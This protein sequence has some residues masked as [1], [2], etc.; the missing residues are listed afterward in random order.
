MPDA[1]K[2]GYQPLPITIEGFNDALL[3][4]ACPDDLEPIPVNTLYVGYPMGDCAGVVRSVMALEQMVEEHGPGVHCYHEIVHNGWVRRIFEDM[5]VV[6]VNSP[7]EVPE[8]SP[9]MLSAHGT[10]PDVKKTFIS[11]GGPVVDSV[12][13]LVRKVHSEV[14][15]RS[16]D[17]GKIIYIGHPG[18]DEVEGVRGFNDDIHIVDSVERVR[19]LMESGVISEEDKVS[20]LMQTTLAE[21]DWGPIDAEVSA[22]WPTAWRPANEDI[23]YATTNRQK[24]ANMLVDKGVDA[25]L[26]VTAPNSSNGK[27][28]VRVVRDRGI[29]AYPVQYASDIP[30]EVEGLNIG[31]TASASSPPEL[32]I[33]Q[34]MARLSPIS[35]ELVFA[36]AETE[37]FDL[38]AALRQKH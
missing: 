33:G 17:N 13:P 19:I 25:I 29:P 37:H 30:Q 9:I 24:A 2:N 28:L 31:L 3:D 20:V 22:Y 34:I 14:E 8:G 5:G 26:V 4:V 21:S 35:M 11:L 27:S 12:C 18:T 1:H 38:P 36:T 7:E 10:A 23:C 32:I 6:F 15:R 16:K